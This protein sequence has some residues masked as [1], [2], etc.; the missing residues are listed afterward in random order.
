MSRDTIVY[1]KVNKLLWRSHS[2]GFVETMLQARH[3]PDKENQIQR[4]P[5]TPGPGKPIISKP[6]PKTPFHDENWPTHSFARTTVKKSVA[7]DQP[8]LQRDDISKFDVFQ[9]P[10]II[11]FT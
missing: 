6:L 7:F 1:W 11:L 3:R 10:G 8:Q 4:L 5:K 2:F 9:T